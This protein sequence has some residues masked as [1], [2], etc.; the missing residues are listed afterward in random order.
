MK[1]G[2]IK[3]C[4]FIPMSFILILFFAG[5]SYG[6][7]P[8]VSFECGD[9]G[10]EA[11][12]ILSNLSE[13]RLGIKER[14]ELLDRREEE[15]NIMQLEVDKKLKRLAELQEELEQLIGQKDELERDKVKKLSMIFQKRDPAEAANSLAAMDKNLAVSILSKM[16]DKYAGKILDQMDQKTAVEY[17]TAL[18]RLDQ[19][20]DK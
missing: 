18:G 3:R 16:R 13:E 19:I 9:I 15:L 10:V 14:Q 12:R 11:R 17:S 7:D 5:R 6:Q 4:S 2:K 1:L 20:D 8:T